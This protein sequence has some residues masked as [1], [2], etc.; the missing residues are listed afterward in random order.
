VSEWYI[1]KGG[2]SATHR[3][4]RELKFM[5]RRDLP[6]QATQ[7]STAHLSPH[8]IAFAKFPILSTAY[9]PSS[10]TLSMPLAT[11]PSLR[12]C[13]EKPLPRRVLWL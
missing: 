7:N 10:S 6:V 5:E 13:M 12:T 8:F 11:L 9:P 2:E 3:M 4:H 1:G